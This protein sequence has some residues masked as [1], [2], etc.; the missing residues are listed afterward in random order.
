VLAEHFESIGGEHIIRGGWGYTKEDACFIDKNNPLVDPSLPFY[1]IGEEYVFVE[2]R[3]YEE[4]I[5]LH[6]AR[7]KF[8]GIKWNLQAQYLVPD[9]GRCFDKIVFEIIVFSDD[10]WK[11]LKAEFEGP[12]GYGT[13][14]FD[15]EAQEKKRQDKMVRFI[16]DF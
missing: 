5:I 16:R 6:R 8:S 14:D 12:K 15:Q 2:K 1:G 3:I 4:M 7:E 10:D 9:D 11:E 13:P